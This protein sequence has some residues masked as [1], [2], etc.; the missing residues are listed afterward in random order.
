M[1]GIVQ[2]Q[3]A[4]VLAALHAEVF[5]TPWSVAAIGELLD[6]SGV[7][8]LAYADGFILCRAV[9]DEAEILTLAVRPTARRGGVGRG[10]VVGAAAFAAGLGAQRLFLEVA[11]DN[12]AA[13]ALYAAVGFREE[14]RRRAY[15]AQSSG[16]AVDALILV[17]NL[18][19][20]LPT[21]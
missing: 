10:L 5:D 1:T 7:F 16:P 6:Q 12:V 18:S 13:R 3:D 17:L 15:Y 8:T 2:A 19:D 11:E 21:D 14:G 9:A 4:A 20:P